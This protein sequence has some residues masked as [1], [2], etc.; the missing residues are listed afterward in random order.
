MANYGVGIGSFLTGITQGAKM[1]S[2]F[3]KGDREQEEHDINMRLKQ[4]NLKNAEETAAHNRGEWDYEASTRAKDEP[5]LDAA[6]KSK[7]SQLGD[8]EELRTTIRGAYDA[9]KG[10]YDALK[11]RSIL[12]TT[13]TQG[14]KHVTV[15]GEEVADKAQ[16]GK[17]FEQKHG[18]F[19]RHYIEGGGA[20]SV[21]D[22]YLRQGKPDMA[23]AFDKWI[24]QDGVKKASDDFGLA[25]Q[26]IAVKDYDTASKILNRVVSNGEYVSTSDHKVK[27]E[28]IFS[29]DEVA[30]QNKI[31][32]NVKKHNGVRV[33]YEDKA[34]NRS[35]QEYNDNMPLFKDMSAILHPYSRF[36]AEKA[37]YD[38]NV[39]AK[40]KDADRASKLSNDIVLNKVRTNLKMS[41]RQ[42]DS[43]LKIIEERAKSMNL[44]PDKV[45]NNAIEILKEDMASGN[46]LLGTPDKNGKITPPTS[47]EAFSRAFD[48]VIQMRR[49]TAA[50]GS[51]P[52][53]QGATPQGG[54]VD[55]RRVLRRDMG[56]QAPSPVR[57]PF[58]P[59]ISR[60]M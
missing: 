44:D 35:V 52:T 32:P 43:S 16:A 10:S 18:S 28:P 7:L 26:A 59:G 4:F 34:G 42:F 6:R 3:D 54:V 50:E 11:A 19:S 56:A 20:A 12:E 48:R 15:D 31:D 22:A 21:R 47:D 41:E 27:Y 5:M 49:A 30:G 39:A 8:E 25:M 51:A 60:G 45:S 37:T 29:S 40:L 58:D 38:A 46:R 9:S 17:L 13:D 2:L 23:E 53:G 55:P 1:R 36:E 33:T 14:K 24:R 57:Q